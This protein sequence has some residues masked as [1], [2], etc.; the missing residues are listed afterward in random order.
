MMDSEFGRGAIIGE[1]DIVD[2]VTES[3]SPWFTGPYGFVLANPVAYK[4]PVPCKGKLGF[5]T[6]DIDFKRGLRG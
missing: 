5:F 3:K 6:P 2:C 1:V 4:V